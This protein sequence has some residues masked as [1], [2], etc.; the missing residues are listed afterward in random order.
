MATTRPVRVMDPYAEQ[1]WAFTQQGELRLQRCAQCSEWRWPAAAVCPSCLS[2]TYDWV[3]VD[4]TGS[5]LTWVTF[6]RQYFLPRTRLTDTIAGT[7]RDDPQRPASLATMLHLVE[8]FTAL[9]FTT[10][11][12]ED[13]V[14]LYDELDRIDD[15][16]TITYGLSQKFLFRDD[17]EVQRE[18]RARLSIGQ[19][20]NLEQ[21][22]IDDHFSDIDFS[23]AVKPIAGVSVSGL[24]SYN[25]GAS[26]LTGAVA[27]FS[28]GDLSVPYFVPRGASLDV[29]YR[30]VRGGE[31]EIDADL[32][33][34]ETLEGRALFQLTGRV[35]FGINGRYDF[36]GAEFVESGGGF[37][38]TSACDCWA[39]DLGVIN[40]VNPDET[41]VRLA[42]ELRGLGGIGSSALDYQTPGLAGVQHGRTIYGRYGW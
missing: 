19:T 11:G 4:G 30:F 21:K 34:L 25:P 22:V 41:E 18:E 28:V 35:A 14:P 37:R 3:A 2:E 36:P 10:A 38:V 33:D 27:E 6:E 15:R 12:D 39:I 1:F 31:A 23:I 7:L 24:T 29:V 16:T 5:L 32:D 17:A 42:I 20:Y 8:P 40:R 13:Q 9:R 26:E